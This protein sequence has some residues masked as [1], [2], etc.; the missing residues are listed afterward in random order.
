MSVIGIIFRQ[1]FDNEADIRD[2]ISAMKKLVRHD[3]N[4]K[5]IMLGGS[6]YKPGLATFLE[7]D[8]ERGLDGGMVRR[9]GR[10]G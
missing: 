9:T 5:I 10:H 7:G 6:F 3:L 4:G 8:R 1:H 2:I